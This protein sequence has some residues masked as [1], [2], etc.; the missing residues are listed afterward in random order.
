MQPLTSVLNHLLAQN[1]WA[2]ERL[3]PYAGKSFLLNL[4]PIDLHFTIAPQGDVASAA[5]L[6]ADV[7]LSISPTAFLRFA[8][9]RPRD[10]ALIAVAGDQELGEVLRA[11]LSELS[12]E[13]EEDLSRVVGDVLAHRLSNAA[14][15]VGLWGKQAVEQMAQTSAEYLSE[16]RAVLVPK[17]ELARFTQEL[18][19]LDLALSQLE[20]RIVQLARS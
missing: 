17:R 10:P 6:P 19:S 20:Q 13:A 18:N 11:V 14:R 7:T 16:E 2:R 4:A 8:L 5:A 9:S 1:A 15:S 3:S 12:W